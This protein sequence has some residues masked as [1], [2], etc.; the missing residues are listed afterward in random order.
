MADHASA[1]ASVADGA[2]DELEVKG[3]PE[4]TTLIR[5]AQTLAKR[6]LDLSG[7]T[8]ATLREMLAKAFAILRA[9][10]GNR[11]AYVAL[12]ESAGH[13][14]NKKLL[15][16]WGLG[17]VKVVFT[18]LK[19]DAESLYGKVLNGLAAQ[20]VDPAKAAAFIEA[21]GGLKATGDLARVEDDAGAESKKALKAKK[22]A[23]ERQQRAVFAGMGNIGTA[24][25]IQATPGAGGF[26]LVLARPNGEGLTLNGV[27]DD[28]D[29][30]E[31]AIQLVAE[32]V[33]LPVA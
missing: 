21:N 14:P 13:E 31:K 30:L 1:A 16:N 27:V 26:V 19:C 10:K 17:T 9:L 12:L 22:E 32:T 7:R 15:E 29:L 4:L 3:H 5:E 24:P 28:A 18:G 2:N 6:L 11:Q 23:R 25:G 33:E 8:D 20:N